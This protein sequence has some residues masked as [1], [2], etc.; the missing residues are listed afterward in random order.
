MRFFWCDF[1]LMQLEILHHYSNLC[2]NVCF[3]AIWK[4]Q[5]EKIFGIMRFGID[6][7]WLH[8]S[9]V[10]GPQKVMSLSHHQSRVGWLR[11][12]VTQAHSSCNA[13]FITIGFWYENEKHKSVSPSAIPVKNLWKTISIE[14]KLTNTLTVKRCMNYLH[15]SL[16]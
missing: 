8:L 12:W 5:Y 7:M 10:R 4:R 3:D 2:D 13:P 16:C 1:S 11:W 9:C 15:M 6:E 14:D